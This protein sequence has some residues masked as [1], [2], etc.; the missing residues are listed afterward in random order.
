[1]PYLLAGGSIGAAMAVA[2]IK[3]RS[4]PMNFMVVANADRY[5]VLDQRKV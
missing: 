2:A 3:A 5:G 4:R 1:M